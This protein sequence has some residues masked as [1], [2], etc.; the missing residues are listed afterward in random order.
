MIDY[1]RFSLQS[2]ISRAMAVMAMVQICVK[3]VPKDTS[4]G[5]ECVQVSFEACFK[6]FPSI[7]ACISVESCSCV[8][9]AL[10]DYHCTFSV[11]LSYELN[12]VCNVPLFPHFV[13][14]YFSGMYAF[15]PWPMRD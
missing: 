6:P 14:I 10:Y 1:I 2:V 3:N 7:S 8:H 9:V 11:V 15:W 13:V 5:T 4:C 12:F